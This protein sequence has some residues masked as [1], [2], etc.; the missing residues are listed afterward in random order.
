MIGN[1]MLNPKIWELYKTQISGEKQAEN[2]PFTIIKPDK[3]TYDYGNIRKG[4][5]NQAV[6]TMENIGNN[7]LV[8]NHVS[9][10]CGCTGVEWEKQP[11]KPGKTTAIRVE[12][13]PEETGYFNKTIEIYG[14]IEQSPMKL[15]VTG[16]VIE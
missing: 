15:T 14:N 9:T 4:I 11:I 12:M 13:T 16:T 6:F 2:A 5:K 3:T 8:I 10:S 1:P 7:P